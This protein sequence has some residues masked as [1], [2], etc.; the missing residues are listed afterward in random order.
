MTF[1]P[2]DEWAQPELDRPAVAAFEVSRARR[3]LQVGIAV[4][5]CLLAAGVVFGYAAIKPVL[6]REGAYRDLCSDEELENSEPVC[7]AQE[8]RYVSDIPEGAQLEAILALCRKVSR[9]KANT[10]RL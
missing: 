8:I 5:Y 3:L 2:V 6:L 1:N 4:L 10:K 7:F 9:L